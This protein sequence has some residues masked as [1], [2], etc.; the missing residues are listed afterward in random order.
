MLN[1]GLDKLELLRIAESVASEKSI[2]KEIIIS[3]MEMAIKKAARTRFG[4][5]NEIR[6]SIDRDTGEINLH[7]VLKIVDDPENL[8]IE[9]SLN[10]KIFSNSDLRVLEVH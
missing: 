7:K 9:I 6:V 2:D 8:N 3:S 5:D 1:R 4:S 10:Y